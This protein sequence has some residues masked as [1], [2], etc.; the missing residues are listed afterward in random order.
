MSNVRIEEQTNGIY[1]AFK[2]D[3]PIARVYSPSA[4]RRECPW[5]GE[6]H[7]KWGVKY[8]PSSEFNCSP[9]TFKDVEYE[10]EN[11]VNLCSDEQL[12]P[13]IWLTTTRDPIGL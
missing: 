8:G 1:L 10:I 11:V 4:V 9:K 12:E 3:K 13:V 6:H 2:G 7:S 5:V